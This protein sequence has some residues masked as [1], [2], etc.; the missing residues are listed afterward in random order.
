[1]RKYGKK[2]L[3][4]VAAATMLCSVA[5]TA[6]CGEAKFTFV[7]PDDAVYSAN[8]GEV[9]SNGGFAVEKGGYVYFINGVASSTANNTYGKVEKG[10]LMRISKAQLKAGEYDKAEIVVP[11]LLVANSYDAGIYVFGDMVYYATPTTDKDLEGQIENHKIDFKYANLK[12]GEVKGKFFEIEASDLKNY[13]FVKEGETVYCLYEDG[14]TLKS[15]NTATDK[16]TVLVKGAT[17]YFF[18]NKDVNNGNVYYTM[19]VTYNIASEIASQTSDYNQLYCVNVADEATDVGKKEA[20]KI[21]YT[22]KDTG[23]KYTFDAKWL[24]DNQSGY[25]ASDYTTYPYVNLG[26][27]VLD[28]VGAKFSDEIYNGGWFNEDEVADSLTFKGYTYTVARYENGGVYFTRNDSTR[29]YYLADEKGADWNTITGNNEGVDE[30]TGAD[31]V[32]ELDIVALNTTNA[33]ASAL[34]DVTVN[35]TTGSAGAGTRTHSIIYKSGNEVY[36]AT[37]KANGEEENVIAIIR[38]ITTANLWKTEG[39]YLY[40][41]ADYNNGN[42][43]SRVNYTGDEDSYNTFHAEEPDYVDYQPVTLPLVEWS[44]DWY[45]PELIDVDGATVLLYANTQKFGNSTVSYNHIYAAK[46]GT[47]AEIKESVEKYEAYQDYLE[48]Y[49]TK[50]DAQNLI[51]YFFSANT[52]FKGEEM[53]LS[54]ETIDLYKDESQ[55]EDKQDALY[56]EVLGKFTAEEGKTAE[57]ATESEFIGLVGKATESDLA[58]IQT[59]WKDT[60]LKPE[61]EEKK[62]NSLPGWAIALIIV[63]ASL[64]VLGGAAVPVVIYFK[65]KA[66]KKKEEE[67]IVN[68][69]RRQ[70][71]DTT[72]DKSINVYADEEK[73]EEAPEAAV[74]STEN[75]EEA[76]SEAAA[77]ETA[78]ATEEQAE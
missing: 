39:N 52:L 40:Y 56:Q 58:D 34:F 54:Q 65:K 12:T 45:K 26:E 47:T 16:T 21:S 8:N 75:A 28:G 64:V 44:K 59:A 41:Y 5:M 25:K 6:A 51:K 63:G 61:A 68:A 30:T 38:N 53:K 9:S 33:S 1:M 31:L 74:E 23:K 60:L 11:S 49:A 71:I 37:A 55:A 14:T 35:V 20:D 36:K 62:D 18:D 70:K 72:D 69:Y 13:R 42:S 24:E 77:E 7:K 2:I 67:A 32:P 27:L 3:G 73:T 19:P 10:A 29:L 57:L 22:V 15:Y 66:A 78:E 50:T 4:I 48:E 43:L 46:V 17:S 76:A